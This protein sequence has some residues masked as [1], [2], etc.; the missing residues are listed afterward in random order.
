MK[1]KIRAAVAAQNRIAEG[2]CDL[3][4]TA[5]EIVRDAR[6]GQFV[7]LYCDDKSRLLPRPVSLAGIDPESGEIRLIY[8]I[9][10]AGTEEFSRLQAGDAIEIMGPLGDGFPTEE[11][12]GRP[13][14]LIGGGIGIPPL[15]ETAKTVRREQETAAGGNRPAGRPMLIAVLGYRDAETF[16]AEEFAAVC[17]RVLIATEDGSAGTP[18]NVLD[19]I[20]KEYPDGI[21]GTAGDSSADAWETGSGGNAVVFA[22]GPAPMLR[23]LQGWTAESGVECWISLEERM[24]CGIGACLAC[25]CRTREIDE[26]SQVKNRR[27]CKDGPVFRAEE[28]IL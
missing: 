4:L 2:I 24:A 12:A 18:G 3:R 1:K 7:D 20:R 15:L 27:I 28:I 13:V 17:D 10:G 26:H 9:S 8:R 25:I 16:L 22:C 23:A 6:A 5:P 14:F 11:T 19:A 21:G